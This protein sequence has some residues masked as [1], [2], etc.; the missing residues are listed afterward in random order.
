MITIPMIPFRLGKFADLVTGQAIFLSRQPG[1]GFSISKLF[2]D[3]PLVG[4]KIEDNLRFLTYAGKTN[5]PII[6]KNN[7]NDSRSNE[8]M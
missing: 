3:C 6:A 5:I 2:S 1:P 4:E 8:T 7:K